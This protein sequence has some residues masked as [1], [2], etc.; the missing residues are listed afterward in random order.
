M[1]NNE[2]CHY[3]LK[4]SMMSYVVFLFI[5]SPFLIVIPV[6]MG[7]EEYVSSGYWLAHLLLLII[8]VA[9]FVFV[10]QEIII[11]DKYI[12]QRK[13]TFK[14][15]VSKI[16]SFDEMKSWSPGQP[17]RLY[18]I[19]KSEMVIPWFTF[20]RSDQKT[21]FESLQKLNLPERKNKLKG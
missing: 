17:Y 8:I 2:K 3:V 14:G 16:M 6:F 11:T 4:T 12:E 13:I 19:N 7:M 20:S 15:K 1:G 21:L 9:L 5:C 18:G 10:Y